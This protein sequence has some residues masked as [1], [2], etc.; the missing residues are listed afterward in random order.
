MDREA[1]VTLAEQMI[2]ETERERAR[3]LV[4]GAEVGNS[5]LGSLLSLAHG[6]PRWLS[7]EVVR[8]AKRRARIR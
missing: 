8:E 2:R 5:V 1:A 4:A 7:E 6:M 3:A